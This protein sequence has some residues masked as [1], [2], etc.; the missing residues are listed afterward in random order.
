MMVIALS[1]Q[2]KSYDLVCCVL[3]CAAL[4]MPSIQ[5]LISTILLIRGVSVSLPSIVNTPIVNQHAFQ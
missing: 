3:C 4:A 5:V 2:V 1:R